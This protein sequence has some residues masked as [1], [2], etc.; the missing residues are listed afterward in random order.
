MQVSG[1]TFD[2]IQM[3]Q[4]FQIFDGVPD[5]LLDDDDDGPVVVDE[6]EEVVPLEDFHT[7]QGLDQEHHVAT[8]HEHLEVPGD[9]ITEVN[10]ADSPALP[11]HQ[12]SKRA[13]VQLQPEN[14]GVECKDRVKWVGSIPFVQCGR[15]GVIYSGR[16]SM[17]RIHHSGY[18]AVTVVCGEECCVF[19]GQAYGGLCTCLCH[20]LAKDYSRRNM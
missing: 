12:P 19:S 15:T 13:R 7:T 8:N 2:Q 17:N 20:E 4:Q 1:C 18:N 9:N 16:S 11:I 6:V 5:T 14:V 3:S 10:P